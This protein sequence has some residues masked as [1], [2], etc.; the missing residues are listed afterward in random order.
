[1]QD[2]SRNPY[3]DSVLLRAKSP[4]YMAPICG[5]VTWLSSMIRSAVSGR[6]SNR[7]GGGSAGARP[8]TP[9]AGVCADGEFARVILGDAAAGD[10]TR[11][12][13]E[14]VAASGEAFTA[15]EIG[16]YLWRSGKEAQ[17]RRFARHHTKDT[18]FY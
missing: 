14:I 16:Y 5:T 12:G 18:V 10:F 1:M 11:I 6:Y 2:G 9:V 7:D 13:E 17:A 15:L 3:S 8:D 4:L